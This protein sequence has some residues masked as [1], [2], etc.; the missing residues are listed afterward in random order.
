MADV[1]IS[2]RNTPERRALVQ[3]LANLLRAH[4]VT[5]WWDYGLE[6]GEPYREQILSELA[7]A[8]IV[9]PLWC[10]ESITSEWVLKEAELGK[11]KLIP[12]RLQKV[13]PPQAFEGIQA[14]DLIGWDGAVGNPRA[15]AFVRRICDRLKRSA[16]APT[17]FLEELGQ[18]PRLT[19]LGEVAAPVPPTPAPAHTQLDFWERQWLKFEPSDNLV[20]LTDIAEGAPRIIANQARAR[21]DEI[22]VKQQ[23]EAEEREREAKAQRRLAVIRA[24][25]RVKTGASIVYGS[26]DDW[27]PPGSGRSEWFKDI[28]FGPEMVVVPAGSFLMG[29][30]PTEPGSHLSE[31]PQREIKIAAPF[32]VSRYAVTTSEWDIAV[33][34]GAVPV[35]HNRPYLIGITGQRRVGKTTVG[36]I[37]DDNDI[38]VIDMQELLE[39]LLNRPGPLQQKVLDRFGPPLAN[40]D[41][42]ISLG[43]LSV[44]V[45]QNPIAQLDLG[46][47][48]YADVLK[49][50]HAQVDALSERDLDNSLAAVIVRRLHEDGWSRQFDETWCVYCD[51]KELFERAGAD[52]IPDARLRAMMDTKLTQDELVERSDRVIDN[53]Y[54][55]EET[56]QM[57]FNTVD[58]VRRTLSQ[59]TPPNGRNLAHNTGS[60]TGVSWDAANTYA[61]W[62]SKETNRDYRLLSEAEWEYCCRAGRTTIAGAEAWGLQNMQGNVW[63]WCADPWHADYTGRPADASVWTGAENTSGIVRGGCWCSPADQI[64]PANRRPYPRRLGSRYVGFRL[65]RAL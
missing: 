29:S 56:R 34:A 30:P 21:I 11:D 32:A 13:S 3:R 19:P 46:M 7:A 42:S 17:D 57:V 50:L 41:G 47:L 49:E 10:A 36:N 33:A 39:F 1:F 24:E 14:A 27:L 15:L 4:A 48:V 60:V 5:V 37:L 28:D 63:E 18:L 22:K 58:D 59:R 55:L 61:A 23:R 9:A 31:R 52:D 16:F 2:Y 40:R 20:A 38:P 51:E 64:R 25:G 53:T 6:A 8:G 43:A 12:A 65:A 35:V 45:D 62:L 44:I 26:V 54:S